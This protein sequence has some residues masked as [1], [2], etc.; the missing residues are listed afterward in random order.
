MPWI[1]RVLSRNHGPI[2]GNSQSTILN[3]PSK[4]LAASAIG[5]GG[6]AGTQHED[7]AQCVEYFFHNQIK[8]LS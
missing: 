1:P 3:G 2:A 5:L 7:D 6:Q 4:I 8:L